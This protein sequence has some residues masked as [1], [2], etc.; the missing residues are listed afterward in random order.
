MK[1]YYFSG[2][3]NAK[4]VS[5][6]IAEKAK[7]KNIN[8]E[9]LDISSLRGQKIMPEETNEMIGFCSPTHGFNLPPIMMNFL[10][11]FPLGKKQKIFII[12]TR[13]GMK[14]G[15]FFIPGLSGFAQ[16]LY[17][18][19]MF[20]KGYKVVGM[21][22]ID[23]P[24][25][26]ISLH[27]GLKGKVVESIHNRCRI[28][29]ERFTEK[30]LSGKKDYRS[31]LALPFDLLIAP[32]AVLYYFIGRFALAKTFYTTSDCDMCELCIKNCP[33]KAIKVIDKCPFWSYR[34]ESCMKC[35]NLCPQRSIQTAHGFFISFMLIIN[36][37]I[38]DRLYNLL[39]VYI[40]KTFSGLWYSN[41]ASYIIRT[42]FMLTVL[43]LLYR[44]I[45]YLMRFKFFERLMI[46]TSL[47][48]FKFWRRYFA[49]KQSAGKSLQ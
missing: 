23:L 38:A 30:M 9:L 29:T 36:L 48:R 25:N 40:F 22:S 49:P 14:I 2:T 18:I 26:W 27:P 41:F 5:Q 45:H 37:V 15:K 44:I 12:N 8:V 20:L 19:V 17:A 10:F 13:A 33:V 46:Y 11:R 28:I 3:G 7:T 6:W 35:M 47:T 16:W 24:S 31:L 42:V 4:R 32:I 39:N 21:R 43:F 1:I 34:C